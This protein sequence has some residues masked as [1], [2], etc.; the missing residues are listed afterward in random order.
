MSEN[1]I[2]QV[3]D[4]ENDIILTQMAFNKCKVPNRLVVVRDG[5]EALDLLFRRGNYTQ[6]DLNENPILVLLDLKLPFV[7]GFEVLRQ[8][9]TNKR[10]D[11]LPVIVLTSSLEE[12]DQTRSRELGANQYYRKPVSYDNFVELIHQICSEWLC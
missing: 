7:D 10:T 9:R 3:E 4:N 8:I 12:T 5:V 6:R 11:Q 1:F 2:L